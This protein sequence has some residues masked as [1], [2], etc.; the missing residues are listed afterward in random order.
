MKKVNISN[1]EWK[2]MRQLWDNGEM[3]VTQLVHALEDDTGWNK[4]TIFTMLKRLEEKGF[5]KLAAE[6][7][8]Q[9]YAAAIDRLEATV[10]ATDSFVDRVFDGDMRL[11]VSAISGGSGLTQKEIDEL[12]AI[13]DEAEKAAKED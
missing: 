6:K 3:T 4:N 8:P 7:R 10:L 1:G 2:L 13:L 5:V 11:F 12:R 9:R